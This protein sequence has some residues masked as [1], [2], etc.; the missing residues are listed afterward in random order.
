VGFSILLERRPIVEQDHPGALSK[1]KIRALAKENA[2]REREGIL[3]SAPEPGDDVSLRKPS[4]AFSPERLHQAMTSGHDGDA[5]LF[6][7]LNR[8]QFRYDHAAGCW[9][10]W[11]KHH[12]VEDQIGEV[13]KGFENVVLEYRRGIDQLRWRLYGAEKNALDNEGRQIASD[14]DAYTTKINQLHMLPW[15]RA[16]LTLAAAGEGSLGMAGDEW[17]SDPWALGCSN[18]V[19]DLRTGKMRPGR[20]SDC[21]K[22]VCPTDYRG[23]DKGA[24]QWERFLDA[25]FNGNGDLVLFVQRLLGYAITGLTTEHIMPILCGQGRNG[26]GTLIEV[27][28]YVLGPLAGPIQSEMLLEQSRSRSSSGP[29]PDILALRGRR[30]AWASETDEG[31]RLDISK[32]KWLCGGDT[33][34]GR[35]LYAKR[36]VSFKPTHQLFL[37]TNNRPL[38]SADDYALWKR[39]ML[40]PFDISFVDEPGAQNERKRN[41]RI[42]EELKAEA[43]GILAWLVEGCL[44]WQKDGCLRPPKIITEATAQYRQSEDVIGQFIEECCSVGPGRHVKA[45]DLYK[46]YQEWCASSGQTSVTQKKFGTRMKSLFES[47]KSS[48]VTYAGIE[49]LPQF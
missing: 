37:L 6:I 3:G 2:V 45:G 34:V 21:I 7:E 40:I 33:L 22:T 30:L 39:M 18:G 24:P 32:V 38:A 15:K 28:G 27:L 9:L 49:L 25:V 46:A 5:E 43:A 47:V 11:E 23:L 12:W 8:D 26:K 14:I 41:P 19:I 20:Q 4:P 48:Q 31:R 44:A 10:I 16:V 17:D 29:S 13:Y 1:D 35:A 36:E 42:L